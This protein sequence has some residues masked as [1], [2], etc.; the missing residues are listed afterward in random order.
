MDRSDTTRRM[1]RHGRR[2]SIIVPMK[3]LRCPECGGTDC[4]TSSTLVNEPDFL[5]QRKKCRTCQ[6]SFV[7][8]S[9]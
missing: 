4:I 2:R 5:S 1:K 8:N 7:V 9:D 3:L 6:L